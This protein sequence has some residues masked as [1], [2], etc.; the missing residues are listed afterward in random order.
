MISCI[1]KCYGRVK[2]IFCRKGSVMEMLKRF[3]KDEQGLETVEWVVMGAVIV[4]GVALLAGLLLDDVQD[5]LEAI[6]G[7][8]QNSI[9]T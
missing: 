6:G 4:L 3:I 1:Q 9:N 5:G 7:E 8:I 2:T